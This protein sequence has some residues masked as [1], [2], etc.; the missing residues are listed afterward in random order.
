[1]FLSECP[2]VQYS[3]QTVC[4]SSVENHVG[5]YVVFLGSF[6]FLCSF[7]LCPDMENLI[8]LHWT[9]SV[10][11]RKEASYSS[12]YLQSPQFKAACSTE[13]VSIQCCSHR[14]CYIPQEAYRGLTFLNFFP[15]TNGL[16][17]GTAV[18][19]EEKKKRPFFII[20][21][22]ILICTSDIVSVMDYTKGNITA[23][24]EKK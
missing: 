20:P 5:C 24:Q 17:W 19:K 13:Q 2:N 3:T 12:S 22:C 1:M 16:C 15:E 18:V 11:I 10:L 14:R 4:L 8:L 9:L 23:Q 21:R 7:P 6:F